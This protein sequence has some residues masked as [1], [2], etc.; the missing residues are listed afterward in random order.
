MCG[1]TGEASTPAMRADIRERLRALGAKAP[2]IFDRYGSTEGGAMAQC[3]EEGDWH[4]PAPEILFHEVVD[5]D[6]GERLPDGERGALALTHLD[7]RGTVLIRYLV[8]DVV[9]L[10]HE[11]CAHCGRNGDRIVPPVVRTKDLLKVKGMLINP[12]VLLDAIAAVPGVDEYQVV[13]AK[14]DP[15]D[16][17]SMDEMLIRVATGR[18]DRDTL[19]RAV[20]DASRH[21]VGVRPRVEFASP[22]EIYDPAQQV[23]ATRLIDRR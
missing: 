15:G 6:T 20:V 4:N 18:A 9:S 8:G 19:A 10:T 11:R 7:R 1:V 2:V 22:G 5:P 23:K 21:G 3:R 12:A 14:Q 13:I 16:A 17:M